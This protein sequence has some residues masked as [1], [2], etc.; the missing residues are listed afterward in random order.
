MDHGGE[1]SELRAQLADQQRQLAAQ[2]AVIA[3]LSRRFDE[4]P[5]GPPPPGA[6]PAGSEPQVVG[7]T[8]ADPTSDTAGEVRTDRRGMLRAA[9]V[10]A[11]GVATGAV[12][13]GQ[14]SPA[15]AAIS[16]TGNPA[17]LG[18]ASPST[19]IGVNGRALGPSGSPIGVFGETN[20]PGGYAV[21][22][23]N[24]AATGTAVG[25]YSTSAS[26]SGVGG[27]LASFGT[28]AA[29]VGVYGQS[30]NGVGT[31]VYG[32]GF[33]GVRAQ[34][35]TG[36]AVQ[37]ISHQT[38]LQLV[39][40]APVPTTG[41]LARSAGEVVY[42][43]NGDLWMCT[44]PGTPGTWRRLAGPA[45]AGS[46]VLLSAPTRVYDSRNGFVPATGPKSPITGA[47]VRVLATKN[48]GSGVPNGAS[49][50]SPP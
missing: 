5:P 19:G 49:G 14:A 38:H 26:S 12:V 50:C 35:T 20:A 33:Y 47:Q 8:A 30:T 23:Q 31:G 29:A 11:A 7:P 22:A 17:V 25:L 37:A 3:E 41:A 18:T 6:A 15:A 36:V 34:T 46:L 43:Q 10:A 28:T 4:A 39:G 42:D 16:E 1:I 21:R 9:G 48:N 13:L 45:T 32:Q 40:P 44:V 2:A 24:T 27:Y